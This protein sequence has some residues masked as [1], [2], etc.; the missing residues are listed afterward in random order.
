MLFHHTRA[1]WDLIL[2]LFAGP[3][4]ELMPGVSL[5]TKQ[6][7]K[8]AEEADGAVHYHPHHVKGA[9]PTAEII[10]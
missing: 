1:D 4:S 2:F 5:P 8:A 10:L 3:T 6:Q 9:P 7:T